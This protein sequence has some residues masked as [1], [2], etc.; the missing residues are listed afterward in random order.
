[1]HAARRYNI[2]TFISYNNINADINRGNGRPSFICFPT[3]IESSWFKC[4]TVSKYTMCLTCGR[5][6]GVLYAGLVLEGF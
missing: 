2:A 3:L 4:W 5:D 1:M 6:A